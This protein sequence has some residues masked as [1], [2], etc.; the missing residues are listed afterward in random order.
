[1]TSDHESIMR[2]ALKIAEECRGVDEV[3]VGALMLHGDEIISSSGNRRVNSQNPLSHAEIH[4]IE[5]AAERLGSWRLENCSLYVTLEPCIMCASVMVQARIPNLVFGASSPKSGVISL[6]YG[7]L[8][9]PRLNHRVNVIQ[10]VL[11]QECGSILSD[12][13]SKLR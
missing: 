4:V 10:G 5:K 2:R 6:E 13:F 1:M 8:D 11:A 3:P 9:D 12:F 7:I